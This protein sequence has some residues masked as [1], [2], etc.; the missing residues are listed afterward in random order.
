M[1]IAITLVSDGSAHDLLVPDCVPIAVLEPSLSSLTG[2][3]R[4]SLR[5]ALGDHL[6]S[7]ATLAQHGVADGAV[8]QAVGAA[9]RDLEVY[10]DPVD[11]VDL[12][13]AVPRPVAG[14]AVSKLPPNASQRAR[15]P[16]RP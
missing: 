13:D 16:A 14:V 7:E 12:V 11:P 15:M 10:D 8:L 1:S 3:D 4:I 9:G 6:D 2:I 5:T